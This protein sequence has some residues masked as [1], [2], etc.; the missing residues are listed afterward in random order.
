MSDI[1]RDAERGD[2]G[3]VR[4]LA[5]VEGVDVDSTDHKGNTPL[6]VAAMAEFPENPTVLRF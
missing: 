3:V 2:L 6:V 5:E 1:H 4:Y